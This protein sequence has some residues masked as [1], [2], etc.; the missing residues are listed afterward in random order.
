MQKD[1]QSSSRSKNFFQN[2]VFNRMQSPRNT[3]KI[4]L[5]PI[6]SDYVDTPQGQKR[7]KFYS[8][9]PTTMSH[10]NPRL[11]TAAI[12]SRF[13]KLENNS[14]AMTSPTALEKRKNTTKM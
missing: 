7:I 9:N 10:E 2:P 13:K 8:S 12:G 6:R 3:G 14:Q 4:T 11:K 5:D 1:S